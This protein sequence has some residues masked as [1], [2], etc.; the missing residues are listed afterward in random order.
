MTLPDHGRIDISVD[1]SVDSLSATVT[2]SLRR[3]PYICAQ[4][5]ANITSSPFRRP[6]RYLTSALQRRHNSHTVQTSRP[7]R[8]AVIGSGPAGFYATYRLL[9]KMDDAVVDMY[10]KLPVPFGL[11]R[12]G[13]A[14][15][16]PEVKVYAAMRPPM[17]T[18]SMA[19]S[20][21]SLNRTAKINSQRSQHP[22]DL[23]S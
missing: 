22:R 18:L 7:F 14:P 23:I 2:M 5:T 19:N 1:S 13:V 4:C 12:Y 6:G 15:D 21:L 3:P 9:G 20:L 10:E 16:H 17:S 8:I 11:S